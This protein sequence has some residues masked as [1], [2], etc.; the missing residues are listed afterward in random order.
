MNASVLC[1][2]WTLDCDLLLQWKLQEALAECE[3]EA[4]DAL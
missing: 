3:A 4:L 1:S 2:S